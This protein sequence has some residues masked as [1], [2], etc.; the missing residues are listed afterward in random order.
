MNFTLVTSGNRTENQMR[1]YEKLNTAIKQNLD[2]KISDFYLNVKNSRQRAHF[3]FLDRN[4]ILMKIH[5]N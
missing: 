2:A 4:K 3:G 5:K 1:S